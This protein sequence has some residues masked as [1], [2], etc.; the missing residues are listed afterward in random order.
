MAKKKQQLVGTGFVKNVGYNTSTMMTSLV[1]R[2][3]SAEVFGAD[4]VIAVNEGPYSD[5]N[6]DV[7]Q[8][9]MNRTA[10][11]TFEDIDELR[12]PVNP[13]FIDIE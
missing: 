6:S 11:F 9:L 8:T 10:T 7:Y 13:Q 12:R 1:V 3:T 2:G 5:Y 4:F